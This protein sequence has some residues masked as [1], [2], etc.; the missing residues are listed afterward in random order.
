[1][2]I[3]NLDLY[4]VPDLVIEISNTSLADDLGT[5]RLLYEELGVS[6]YWVI[7]SKKTEI[8]AFRIA[9]GGDSRIIESQVL[10]GLQLDTM[11]HALQQSRN[12]NHSAV[13]QWLMTQ[14]QG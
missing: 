1:M 4:P 8:I 3:V 10:P 12:T 6:E 11:I 9:N 13:S 2:G 7:D 14:F 5:K